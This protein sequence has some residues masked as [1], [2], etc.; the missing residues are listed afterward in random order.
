MT[1]ERNE[2]QEQPLPTSQ[3]S[4]SPSGGRSDTPK[5][6]DRSEDDSTEAVGET[7][8]PKAHP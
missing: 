7:G 1:D 2:D 5:P 6:T 4:I 8:E 3:D